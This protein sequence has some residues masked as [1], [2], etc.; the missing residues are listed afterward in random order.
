MKTKYLILIGVVVFIFSAILN[1]PIALVYP[2]LNKN[3]GL[4]QLNGLSG[5]I[6]NG[7]AGELTYN[8]RSV[9]SNVEW[10]FSPLSLLLGRLAFNIRGGHGLTVDGRVAATP[11][12][13][14]ADGLKTS[15]ALS[16]ALPL[17]SPLPLPVEGQFELT[18]NT[19]KF[20]GGYP[21]TAKG[22]L[23]LNS[24]HW[25]LGP[26]PAAIGDLSADIVTEK[27]QIVARFT[28]GEG[29]VEVGGEIRLLSDHN[30]E[31][32]LQLKAKPNADQTLQN[33]LH[34]LGQADP[35]GY[36]HISSRGQL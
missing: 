24:V 23:M 28:P 19:L 31:V 25:T 30:Y 2:K 9:L 27:D 13:P 33:L 3:P 1:T 8:G 32:D 5:S 35:Q 11:F 26:T 6:S 15:G 12:G 7:S 17:L 21:T 4:L 29:A 20:S 16:T 18:L 36:F 14:R 34:T 10:H 22:H